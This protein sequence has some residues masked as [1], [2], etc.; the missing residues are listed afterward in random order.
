MLERQPAVTIVSPTETFSFFGT[1]SKISVEAEA[2]PCLTMPGGARLDVERRDR[3]LLVGEQRHPR[4]ARVDARHAAE[5]PVLGDDRRVER[6]AV[7][8]ADRD[9]DV[10][11]RS[12]PVGRA[13]TAAARPV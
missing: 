13:I 1:R 9:D 2:R 4:R 12:L 11:A 3:E 5:E 8:R 10:L 6:D 7:V